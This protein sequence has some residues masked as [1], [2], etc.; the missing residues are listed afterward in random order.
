LPRG[1]QH[2]ARGLHGINGPD[3]K[4]MIDQVRCRKRE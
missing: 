4:R 1:E 2:G 3:A